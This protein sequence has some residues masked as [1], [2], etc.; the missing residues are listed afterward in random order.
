MTY[1]KVEWHLRSMK[2]VFCCQKLPLEL[3]NIC[4][5]NVARMI[6]AFICIYQRKGLEFRTKNDSMYNNTTR[7]M[8][9]NEI[10]T[11][12]FLQQLQRSRSA[13]GEISTWKQRRFVFLFSNRRSMREL[14]WFLIWPISSRGT[15]IHWFLHVERFGSCSYKY[16]Q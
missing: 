11:L 16:I 10:I 8:G 5:P 7:S 14:S 9:S 13:L 1:S 12:P 3:W 15:R 6:R 4:R 2:E